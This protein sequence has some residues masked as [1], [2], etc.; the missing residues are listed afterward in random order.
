MY[1]QPVPE[2]M[3]PL[4]YTEVFTILHVRRFRG[5]ISHIIFVCYRFIIQKWQVGRYY[6][7]T[8]VD[9]MMNRRHTADYSFV[10]RSPIQ[11]FTL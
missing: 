2:F 1:L 4:T 5:N 11:W 7:P 6:C 8:S 9:I 3:E 10:W